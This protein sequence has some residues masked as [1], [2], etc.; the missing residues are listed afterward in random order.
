[1][2]EIRHNSKIYGFGPSFAKVRKSRGQKQIYLRLAD[3]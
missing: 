1:M 2:D 3:A